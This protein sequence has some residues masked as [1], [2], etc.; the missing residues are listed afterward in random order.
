MHLLS[1]Y[2][3]FYNIYS[4]VISTAL[5]G[6]SNHLMQPKVPVRCG[7]K[8]SAGLRATDAEQ[9]SVMSRKKG[10]SVSRLICLGKFEEDHHVQTRGN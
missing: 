5:F 2:K 7:C 8:M 9:P 10:V 6:L 4:K 3:R 1:H